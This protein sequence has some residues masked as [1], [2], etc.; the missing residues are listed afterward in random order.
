MCKHAHHFHYLKNESVNVDR[1]VIYHG[2]FVDFVG[3]I[4]TDFG[5]AITS[6]KTLENS[7]SAI[8]S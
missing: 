7:A 3:E 4:D 8:K 5:V 6:T 1:P 2:I